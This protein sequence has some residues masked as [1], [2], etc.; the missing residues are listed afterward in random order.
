MIQ[1]I[2]SGA[3]LRRGACFGAVAGWLFVSPR[4]ERPVLVP[5]AIAFVV[6]PMPGRRVLRRPDDRSDLRRVRDRIRPRGVVR[7]EACGA[8]A[9]AETHR[10][11]AMST[12]FCIIA[13]RAAR[14]GLLNV[15]AAGAERSRSAA[16][17]G[18]QRGRPFVGAAA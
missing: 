2:A 16:R 11:S 7:I 4:F 5:H 17:L 8:P 9:M 13:R 1:H 12:R 6:R 10:C 14:P 18:G 3:L 15:R